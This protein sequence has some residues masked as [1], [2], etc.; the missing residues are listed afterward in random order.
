MEKIINHETHGYLSI[1]DTLEK[2]AVRCT[3]QEDEY[4]NRKMKGTFHFDVLPKE[5]PKM[6]N[7]LN[8]EFEY[9][10]DNGFFLSGKMTGHNYSF[11]INN[12][13]LE[14]HFKINELEQWIGY[15]DNKP[16][17]MDVFLDIPYL[18]LFDRG[19][20]FGKG[21]TILEFYKPTIN[22]HCKP[23]KLKFST[24]LKRQDGDPSQIQL[25]KFIKCSIMCDLTGKPIK[26]KLTEIE[27][28]ADCV[29]HCISFIIYHK[30]NWYSY[31]AYGYDETGKFTETLYYKCS[32]YDSGTALNVKE[33]HD[34][35]QHFK[36]KTLTEIS[37]NYMKLTGTEKLKLNKIINSF[38]TIKSLSYFEAKF[39]TAFSA[40]EGICKLIKEK[41]NI[42]Y[43]GKKTNEFIEL[44]LNKTGLKQ[45]FKLTEDSKSMNWLITDY[46]NDLIHYNTV[47][48]YDI[49]TLAEEFQKIM[50]IS[51]KLIFWYICKKHTN[52]P[53]PGNVY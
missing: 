37:N 48:S 52:F 18:N 20:V 23:Y 39:I 16:A 31:N 53:F 40:L 7:L 51:R 33:K 21:K 4:S 32:K 41:K 1:K 45:D 15:S 11:Q 22:I 8:K 17:K 46:R 49:P 6:M 12:K 43:N 19:N 35:Y 5:F 38:L 42:T 24:T 44:I 29:F 3:F 10:G 14:L 36:S 26:T 9:D 47:N 28:F 50:V 27:E 2:L 34:F 25:N 30:V 13:K